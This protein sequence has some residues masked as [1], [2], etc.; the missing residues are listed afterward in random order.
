MQTLAS[1][2]EALQGGSG[3]T[4]TTA[5]AG[6]TPHQIQTAQL[7]AASGIPI[8]VFCSRVV[9]CVVSIISFSG[10]SSCQAPVS[11]AYAIVVTLG[12]G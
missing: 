6:L 11:V 2:L 7:L 10:L 5:A 1:T 4:G 8:Q 9:V 12:A 3:L